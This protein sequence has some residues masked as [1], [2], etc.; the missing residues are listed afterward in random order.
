MHPE[1]TAL[2][3]VDLQPDFMPGGALPCHEGD[4]IVADIS[5]LLRQ[6]RYRTVVATQDWHPPGHASFASSHPGRRPFEQIRL[7]GQPQTLWPDH[8]VQGTPGAALDPRVDWSAADLVLRKGTRPQV[9]SYS[10][11]RENHGPDGTRPP[12][13]LAGWLRERGIAEV[14][15]CGLAR[16]YCVLWTAQDAAAAGFRVRFLWELTRPVTP[17]GDAPTR[18][19]LEAAGIA[20]A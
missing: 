6:R 11:F 8:C 19:A 18:A 7:H 2:I 3:V 14:H 17:E 9:D 13:G 16:D 10:A 5:A 1:S 4:A 15:V 12:T 20:I